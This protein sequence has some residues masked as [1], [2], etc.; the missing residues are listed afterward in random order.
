MKIKRIENN[1]KQREKQDINGEKV[2]NMKKIRG[3]KK[4]KRKEI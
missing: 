1:R 4:S 3:D 2:R